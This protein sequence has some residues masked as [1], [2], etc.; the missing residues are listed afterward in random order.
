MEIAFPEGHRASQL[1]FISTRC[2]DDSENSSSHT[3]PSVF[4]VCSKLLRAIQ[5]SQIACVPL[6]VRPASSVLGCRSEHWPTTAPSLPFAWVFCF[7]LI[8]S[9]RCQVGSALEAHQ[10]PRENVN[11]KREVL[12]GFPES[13]QTH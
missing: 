2:V 13:S 8:E 5:M 4:G 12:L 3:K 11:L 9:R 1:Y 10:H 7:L 6:C